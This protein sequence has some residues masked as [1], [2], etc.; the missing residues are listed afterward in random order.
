MWYEYYAIYGLNIWTGVSPVGKG[1][2]QGNSFFMGI[3]L[4]RAAYPLVCISLVQEYQMHCLP[5]GYQERVL[6]SDMQRG[7]RFVD[8]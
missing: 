6:L 3:S 7:L 1:L 2:L 4:T 5:K 8:Q